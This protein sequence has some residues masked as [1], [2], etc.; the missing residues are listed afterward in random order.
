MRSGIGYLTGTA[1][2]NEC[3]S[4]TFPAGFFLLFRDRSGRS[5]HERIN[6]RVI[7]C[8]RLTLQN[9]PEPRRRSFQSREL[10]DLVEFEISRRELRFRRSEIRWKLMFFRGG[11]TV[12]NRRVRFV[13]GVNDAGRKI[14]LDAIGKSERNTTLVPI[15]SAHTEHPFARSTEW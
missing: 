12:S 10:F 13:A 14:N 11:A 2:N 8:L 9:V 7:A 5:S 3:T 6:Y 15:H 1:F 4:I